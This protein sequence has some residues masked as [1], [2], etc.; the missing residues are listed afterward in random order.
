MEILIFENKYFHIILNLKQLK[1][2]F[3]KSLS[4]NKL[5]ILFDVKAMF[6]VSSTDNF[7]RLCH[8]I[9]FVLLLDAW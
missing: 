3:K 6:V 9:G 4:L 8:L 7:Y 1:Q 2:I 5:P